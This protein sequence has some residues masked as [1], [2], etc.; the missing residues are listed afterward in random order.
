MLFPPAES[1][2]LAVADWR[3]HPPPPL[4]LEMDSVIV[5]DFPPLFEEFRVKCFNLLWRS[6]RNGFTAQEFPL[7]CDGRTNTL[8]LISDTDG[9]VFGGFTP[10]KW[11]NN[12]ESQEFEHNTLSH[13]LLRLPFCFPPYRPPSFRISVTFYPAIISF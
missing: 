5:S 10:V 2:W 12:C 3:L 6:S 1:V 11:G 13:K 4:A 7:R 8:T 9:N